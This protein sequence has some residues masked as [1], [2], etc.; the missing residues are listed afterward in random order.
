MSVPVC[1]PATVQP[2]VAPSSVSS[3]LI[4]PGEER[5]RRGP[6]LS[7]VELERQQI[8]EE[9]KKRTQLLTDNSWI[10][11]RSSSVH[12]EP[13]YVPLKRRAW[14][15]CSHAPLFFPIFPS[16]SNSLLLFSCRFE[17]LD[18]LDTF[19][20]P[21]ALQNYPRPHSAAAG[22]YSPCKSPARYSTGSVLP[23]THEPA[24]PVRC[25]SR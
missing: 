23:Q 25:E 20:Q 14:L 15:F 10:R 8:L 2:P 5:K 17:S 24:H 3:A 19:Q 21:S 7:K 22:F 4:D 1:P 16:S 18:N 6:S 11:Q 9:M 13:V 12:K